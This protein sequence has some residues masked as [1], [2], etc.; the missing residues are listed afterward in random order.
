MTSTVTVNSGPKVSLIELK[1][2]KR[3]YRKRK[4]KTD[5]SKPEVVITK[6]RLDP[7]PEHVEKVPEGKE[8]NLEPTP[9]AE[10][11]KVSSEM[12]D[13]FEGPQLGIQQDAA[14]LVDGLREEK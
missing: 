5:T 3:S 4:L 14:N 8:L 9:S 11:V 12:T 2:T 10:S 6:P 1:R 7:A 13:S